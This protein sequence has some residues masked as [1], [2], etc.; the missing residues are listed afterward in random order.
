MRKITNV[1]CGIICGALICC[2]TVSCNHK[3]V[4]KTEHAGIVTTI[5]ATE[6]TTS[7]S[8]TTTTTTM[9]STGAQSL[10]TSAKT[11]TAKPTTTTSSTSTE[12]IYVA[13]IEE[14]EAT[15]EV[16]VNDVTEQ[17]NE[18][19]TNS[20]TTQIITTTIET[21]LPPEAT[22]AECQA[23]SISISKD[24][25]KTF[26][27]C[28]YYAYGHGGLCGGSGRSL[29]DCSYG[30][31]TVKGSIASSYLYSNYGYN[32]NGSRTM[33]YLEVSQYPQMTGYYYLDDCCAFYLNDTIDFYYDYNSNCPFQYQGV[34]SADCYIITE[35]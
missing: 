8:I 1:I 32:Y 14:T 35:N 10:T 31:G 23:S 19:V 4:G 12:T 29:I 26:N 24:F 17:K 16:P 2:S 22:T 33:V 21:T 20:P 25:V 30:N 18:V 15:Q 7:T 11:T 6:S 13:Q 3:Q 9:T 28:T 27:R 5:S 34:I